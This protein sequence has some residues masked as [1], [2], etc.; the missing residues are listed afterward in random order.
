MLPPLSNGE[1]RSHVCGVCWTSK[2][3]RRSIN[4]TVLRDIKDYLFEDYSLDNTALP[5][6]ICDP[7]RQ[8]LIKLRGKPNKSPLNNINYSKLIPPPVK[9][10]S[11]SDQCTCFLCSR[12]RENL[13]S[14]YKGPSSKLNRNCHGSFQDLSLLQRSSSSWYKP[15][16]H[17]N[18]KTQECGSDGQVFVW[19]E[20][21]PSPLT[22]TEG[23][24]RKHWF[25]FLFS[26]Y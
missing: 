17:K 22:V 20:Q 4:D 11:S 6:V 12:G 7:C 14:G 2:K 13:V 16:L 25:L 1:F 8:R 3:K 19:K 9:T 15:C 21:E 24:Q 23:N 5:T 18:G 10:R 26:V